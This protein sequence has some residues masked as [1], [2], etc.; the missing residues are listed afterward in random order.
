MNYGRDYVV[1]DN[2]ANEFSSYLYK[3]ILTYNNVYQIVIGKRAH[4]DKFKKKTVYSTIEDRNVRHKFKL[5]NNKYTFEDINDNPNIFINSSYYVSNLS[6]NE[7]CDKTQDDPN[8]NKSDTQTKEIL[9]KDLVY[10]KE[11]MNIDYNKLEADPDGYVRYKGKILMCKHTLLFFQE[12]SSKEIYTQCY[13]EN[14]HRC[15]YCENSLDIIYEEDYNIPR[16][17]FNIF[18]ETLEVIK[19][20]TKYY[21]E[22]NTEIIENFIK[23]IFQFYYIHFDRDNSKNFFSNE[24][25]NKI[26][27]DSVEFIGSLIVV[28][29]IKELTLDKLDK[30]STRPLVT[31]CFKIISKRVNNN[32][33][34]QRFLRVIDLTPILDQTVVVEKD[35]SVKNPLVELLTPNNNPI[36]LVNINNHEINDLITKTKDEDYIFK[37]EDEIKTSSSQTQSVCRPLTFEKETNETQ[38]SIQSKQD[39]T[40]NVDV[41]EYY[42]VKVEDNNEQQTKKQASLDV[43]NFEHEKIKEI[44]DNPEEEFKFMNNTIQKINFQLKITEQ[45]II[46]KLNQNKIFEQLYYDIFKEPVDKQQL[47]KCFIKVYLFEDYRED[48]MTLLYM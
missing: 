33:E 44:F 3:Y 37:Q 9:L 28:K 19:A 5:I 35:N 13:D 29:L 43:V 1:I 27:I 25:F 6:D 36:K 20:H 26:P 21:F 16:N 34:L 31:N 40:K 42:T 14:T 2:K 32:V 39:K 8:K 23:M 15:K 38:Q 18:I 47:L 11:L 46:S 48:L 4:D 17:I 45:E 7:I 24:E 12:K 41:I 22:Y 10:E 30:Q